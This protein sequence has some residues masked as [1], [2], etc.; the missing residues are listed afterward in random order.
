MSRLDVRRAANSPA[1][2]IGRL[3][4]VALAGYWILLFTATHVPIDPNVIGPGNDKTLHVVGYSGLAL[5]FGVMLATR[6]SPRHRF[7]EEG[8]IAPND[9]PFW[10][11]F[12]FL[13]AFVL[14]A[15][16]AAFDELTQPLVGRTCDIYDWLADC[17]G[18]MI[19]LF[20]VA[21][22]SRCRVIGK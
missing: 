11:R 18:I 17:A 16:Y 19:G 4:I 1:T 14:L 12:P 3:A 5:L 21:V 15:I 7:G 20:V 9:S 13:G 2:W 8:A 6:M 10:P 22:V